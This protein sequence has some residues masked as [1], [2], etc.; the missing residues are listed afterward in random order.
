MEEFENTLIVIHNETCPI[1]SL[2][3][4]HH[5]KIAKKHNKP[6]IFEGM[7]GPTA[8]QLG[9]TPQEAAKTFHVVKNGVLLE[10]VDA[11][12]ALWEEQPGWRWAATI[13]K[14]RWV[15]PWVKVAY[16]HALAPLLF[17]LHQRRSKK[18]T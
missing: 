13:T 7:T 2:E 11:F 4:R 6:I 14:W 3:I 9:L 5:K 17:K 18:H 8:K 15:K 16:N 10:G 12:V 1:C